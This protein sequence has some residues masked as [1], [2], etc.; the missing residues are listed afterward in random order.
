MKGLLVIPCFRCEKQITRVIEAL[1]KSG[2]SQIFEEII[3]LDNQSPDRTLPAALASVAQSSLAAKTRVCLNHKNYGLGG[4]QKLAFQMARARSVDFFAV[5]HGDDQ[6]DVEDLPTLIEVLKQN[7]QISAVLGS[8]FSRPS[9]RENYQWAR[10]WGNLFLNSLFTLLTGRWTVDLGS[11]LNVFRT[12]DL[13]EIP[14][15]SFSSDF[16]F[17]VDLLLALYRAGRKVRF[18]PIRW[19]VFDQSSNARNFSVAWNM[20]VTLWRWRLGL[21]KKHTL[22]QD[23]GTE[24]IKREAP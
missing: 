8:R 11:G 3:I 23:F 2:A 9:R 17:N 16:T 20:I 18:V 7:P 12:R 13:A 1:S 21:T 14:I 6:A 15:E 24:I 22:P 19:R 4:S 5:L 10:L